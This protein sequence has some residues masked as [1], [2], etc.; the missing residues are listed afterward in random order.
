M[1]GAGIRTGWGSRLLPVAWLAVL[2]A[3][4]RAEPIPAAPPLPPPDQ[5]YTVRGRIEDLPDPSRPASALRIAHEPIRDFKDAEGTTIGMSAM[6]ME[7]PVA[8]GVSLAGVSLRDTV[9]FDFEV[10]WSPSRIASWRLTRIVRLPPGTA[11]RF[12]DP[13]EEN[14]G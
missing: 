12:D 10:R 8:P 6:V 1:A 2:G 9:E 11:L 5:V 13:D 3:C 4:D 7:F 14:G